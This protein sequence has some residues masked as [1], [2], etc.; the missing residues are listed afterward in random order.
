MKL[1]DPCQHVAHPQASSPQASPTSVRTVAGPRIEP[2]SGRRARRASLVRPPV[3]A[4]RRRSHEGAKPP[5]AGGLPAPDG[6]GPH[7]RR[8]PRRRWRRW[9]GGRRRR[10]RPRWT[11]AGPLRRRRCV[12]AR[13]GRCRLP[14]RAGPVAQVS[15]EELE[16]RL[17][18]RLL[19][20]AAEVD[21]V[22]RGRRGPPPRPGSL[23]RQA[24]G[25]QLEDPASRP[26]RARARRRTRRPSSVG[27]KHGLE[28]E[29]RPEHLRAR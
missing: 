7:P 6:S 1:S 28:D 4:R 2:A 10:H 14:A 13:P 23:A 18:L 16:G 9:S 3:D 22:V 17:G 12:P 15:A 21:A 5:E 11:A 8:R 26:G 25:R 19:R 20:T 27:L 29:R 24:L